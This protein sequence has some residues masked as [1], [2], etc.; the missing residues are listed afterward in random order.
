MKPLI[1]NAPRTGV[2]QSPHVGFGDV[3][4]LDIFTSPGSAIL[5]NLTAKKSSTTVDAQTYWFVQDP[6]TPANIYALDSNG[7]VYNS[8]DS[9]VTWAELSDRG[10]SGQG[11]AIWKDYL[12]VAEDT[13]L[14]V[15]GP[16]SGSPT[17]DDNWQTIDSDD[18][19]HP[20]IVSKNDNK[21]YGGAGRYVFSLDEVSGQ[22][23]DP[24]TGGTFTYT[25]QALDLPPNYR[26]K[27]LEELGNN[28]MCGTWQGSNIYDLRIADIFPWDRSATS[29]GQPITMAEN[30]V[31]AM[32]NTG[33]YL[34]VLAGI[35][36]TVYKCNGVTAYPIAQIPQSIANLS[37]GKYLEWYPG[38][39]ISYKGRPF[40]GIG[41]SAAM[42]GMGV[43]SLMETNKG[44]ILT[45]EHTISS[46]NDGTSNVLKVSALFPVTRDN[47]LI[48]WQDNTTYGID[49]ITT[50]SYKT[51]YSGY[52]D[53]AL[54]NIGGS[55]NKRQFTELEFLLARP[56]R[57]NEGI[58]IQYRTNLTD[59]FTTIGTYIF[60]GTVDSTTKEVGA[61][62]STSDKVNISLSEFIQARV[63]LTGTTTSPELRSIILK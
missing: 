2:A 41:G 18:K 50:T 25:Q 3:R 46:G 55:L 17:W 29:F 54:Y 49:N 47:M 59:S 27:C 48:G 38:S 20:M 9:G 10:G 11:L 13:T 37:G 53:S 52:F 19:W 6:G 56:L 62:Q 24:D 43:Y 58:R 4:N 57:T 32:L 45:N 15:Y 14:D 23:F 26:I 42:S 39:L 8:T 16:L 33:N 30:G 22:T 40:F 1:I 60:S 34:I 61:V 44:N 51:S 31:H 36:G 5:N 35:G 28:L 7:V 12:F 63:L 21:L